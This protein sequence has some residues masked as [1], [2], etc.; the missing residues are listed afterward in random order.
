[1]NP[2]RHSLS[3]K[4]VER[5]VAVCSI[6]GP[7]KIRKNGRTWTCARKRSEVNNRWKRQNAAKLAAG[8]NRPSAHHLE[9]YDAES[10]AGVCPVC[11]PVDIVAWGR[12]YACA[13]RA[14][15]LRVL[16]E[17]APAERCWKC[18][19]WESEGNPVDAGVCW[20]CQLELSPGRTLLLMPG[21]RA[22]TIESLREASAY[23][24]YEE[25]GMHVGFP[26]DPYAVDDQEVVA[27]WKVIGSPLPT[28]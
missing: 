24:E 25:A 15:Q 12:G 20:Q 26:D 19:A 8:R 23:L 4:D 13:N 7:V 3:Q 17:S 28:R 6:C 27:G 11:G 2:N 1:M 18:G 22:H 10:R 16:Q 9:T 21:G 14:R 5:R